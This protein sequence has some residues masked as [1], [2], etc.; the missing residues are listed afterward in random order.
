MVIVAAVL[1]VLLGLAF[2]F[3]GTAKVRH[4]EPVTT[5]LDDLGVGRSLQTFIGVMEALGG[6]GVVVGLWIAPLGI[7]AAAGLV[8]MMVGAL[9]WHAKAKDTV[10]NSVGALVLLG[11][12]TAVLVL[13]AVTV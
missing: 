13:Q 6:I 9:L 7:L 5:T 8:L 1:T 3:A 10:K 2:L 11:F 4:A 12:T